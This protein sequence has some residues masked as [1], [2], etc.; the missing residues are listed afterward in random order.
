MR[1]TLLLALILGLALSASAPEARSTPIDLVLLVDKSL[2][3]ESSIGKVKDY[4]AGEIIGPLL[5]PGDRLII[6][7][8]YGSIDRLYSGTIGS[9]SDKARVIRSLHEIRADGR[10]TDIGAAL[11]RAKRDLE[12]LGMPERPK[13][14]LLITDE[15][16][17]APVGTKYYFGDHILRH[18]ALD[19]VKKNDL[20]AF[21]VIAVGFGVRDKVDAATAAVMRLLEESAL[22]G[23][24]GS[25]AAGER[26]STDGIAEDGKPSANANSGAAGQVETRGNHVQNADDQANPPPEGNSR[27]KTGVI[28]VLIVIVLAG[29]L[30]TALLLGRKQKYDEERHDP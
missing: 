3:M 25:T 5:A 27:K 19:Y 23:Q 30:I 13:Y 9:E 8:F 18:P 7:L 6:E 16:Q 14:V 22:Q 10:F 17:E 29:F 24:Y 28:I 15:R 4:V 2:S 1:R 12:E 20:G 11:D 21:R 26:G